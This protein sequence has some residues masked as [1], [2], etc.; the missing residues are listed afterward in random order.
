MLLSGSISLLRHVGHEETLLG[1]METPG[2]WAGGFQA[3]DEHGVYLRHR[4]RCHGR[5]ASCWCRPSVCVALADA[6]FPF[7]V[8]LIGGL[9]EHGPPDRVRR[10]AA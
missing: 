3:W 10:A 8:H 4:A 9:V 2:Q 5:D 6:W 7:G 1:V